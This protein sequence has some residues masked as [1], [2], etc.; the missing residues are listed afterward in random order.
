[1]NRIEL[2]NFVEQ[3]N[4][5]EKIIGFNVI[6]DC[7]K[8]IQVGAYTLDTNDKSEVILS[9]SQFPTQYSTKSIEKLLK[10]KWECSMGSE[11]PDI[12]VYNAKDWY[13]MRKIALDTI[14]SFH[15]DCA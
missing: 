3:R 15:S 1:M 7:N 2:Q 12:E 5:Y 13:R 6:E 4:E 8:I 14:I 9:L 10:I 11:E